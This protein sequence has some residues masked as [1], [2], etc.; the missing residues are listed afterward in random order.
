MTDWMTLGTDESMD[1]KEGAVGGAAV[2]LSANE[3]DHLKNLSSEQKDTRK[4]VTILSVTEEFRTASTSASWRKLAWSSE[5]EW[6]V[7]L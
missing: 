6:F 3:S 1:N 4:V 5:R 2:N 7:I